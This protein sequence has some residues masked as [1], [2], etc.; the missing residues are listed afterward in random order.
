MTI[1]SLADAFVAK[2]ASVTVNEKAMAQTHFNELC[3][4][5]D[6]PTPLS[7]PTGQTYR[8]EKP[9]TKSGGGA[10]FADVWRQYLFAWEYK[11]KGKDLDAAYRQLQLYKEDLDNPPV[12]VVSDIE[13]IEIHVVFTGYPTVVHKI[14]NTDIARPETR[15]IL[16]WALSEPERLRPRDSTVSMTEKAAGKFAT[17]AQMIEGRGYTAQ[18]VAPFFMKILFCLFAEDIGI[19]PNKVLTNIIDESIRQPSEFAPMTTALFTAVHTGSYFG[20]GQKLVQVEGTL[21]ADTTAIALTADELQYLFEAAKLDWSQVEPSIFGTLFERSLDPSK[22]AQL[23]AHYTSRDDILLVIEPVLMQP[24]RQQWEALQASLASQ[25]QELDGLQQLERQ[26]AKGKIEAKLYQFAYELS[27]TITLDPACGS[28][29]FLYVALGQMLDLEKEL[30]TYAAGVGLTPP[31]PAVRPNNFLGI[32]KN[33]F[34]A[35]LARVVLTIGYVQWLYTNGFWQRNQTIQMPETITNHDAILEYRQDGTTYRPDWPFAHVIV[36]NPPFLGTKRMRAELGDTY[37]T[38]LHELYNRYV[39]RESDLVCYWFERARVQLDANQC[40]RVGLIATQAIR[41]GANRKVLQ[42]ILESGRIFYA[43]ADREWVL[44]GAAVRVSMVAFDDG[45]EKLCVLDGMPVASIHANLTYEADTTQAVVLKENM[46]IAFMGDTKQGP[47]DIDSELARKMLDAHNS[48]GRSNRDVVRPWMNGMDLTR[49]PRGMYI[50][51]YGVDMPLEEAALYEAPFEYVKEHVLPDRELNKRDWYKPEWWLHYAPRPLMRAKLAPLN[52]FIATT[53]VS[54]HRLFNWV[55]GNTL[56]DHQL[57]VFTRD[58]DY[59]F[60]VLHSRVHEL[61][62]RATGTQ[63]R[64]VE[65]GF[66]YTPSTCFE[67]FPLP[68][69]PGHEPLDDPRV[70]EIAAAAAALVIARDAWLNPTDIPAAELAKRTLT[71][72]YNLS[73]AWLRDAHARLDAAVCAAYGWPADL[74][75]A[76]VIARLL[77]LNAERAKAQG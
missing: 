64:E 34:A 9:L 36:G 58:D 27:T 66:R 46:N 28:G 18:Q 14:K 15:D 11:G 29:N 57:I 67:T 60:G 8:F 52:R 22:R 71:N 76:E 13:N 4:L 35:E 48:S 7:D 24:L 72:L 19:F 61:W 55:L 6:V 65:S 1:Q 5:V 69:A 70:H 68:W 10:G 77:L 50:I 20:A 73:P 21:F 43:W 25:L 33:P 54:K 32:E 39:A 16:R 41:G 53:T 44:D 45:T 26:L 42:R 17:V 3:V 56:P 75:D 31:E 62:A 30:Y 40:Q 47:F 37:V 2:W 59:F 23:G 74:A 63:L 38:D 49:R 51:D 12:L